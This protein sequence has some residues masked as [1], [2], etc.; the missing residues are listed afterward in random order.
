MWRLELSLD[1]Y[2][3][4]ESDS[5]PPSGNLTHPIPKPDLESV[6]GSKEILPLPVVDKTQ[7]EKSQT[8][9]F[10]HPSSGIEKTDHGTADCKEKIIEVVREIHQTAKGTGG[11]DPKSFENENTRYVF[12]GTEEELCNLIREVVFEDEE[13]KVYAEK[14]DQMLKTWDEALTREEGRDKNSP[15]I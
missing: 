13:T 10:K 8:S 9:E 1:G 3:N 7:E 5:N 4:M 14:T 2:M 6:E 12:K 11:V 15:A